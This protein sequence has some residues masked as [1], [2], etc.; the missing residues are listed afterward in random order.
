MDLHFLMPAVITQIFNPTA[1]LAIPTGIPTKEAKV[2]I[3]TH[4]ATAEAK[5]VSVQYDFLY[6]LLIKLFGFISS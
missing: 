5:Q 1:D 3:K 2:D 4:P 6:F